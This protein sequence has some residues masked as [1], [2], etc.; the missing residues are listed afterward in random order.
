M[1][2]DSNLNR[3]HL[4]PMILMDWSASMKLFHRLAEDGLVL[5]PESITRGFCLPRWR[6]S[7]IQRGIVCRTGTSRSMSKEPLTH[8]DGS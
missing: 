5:G 2:E 3:H 8:L 6:T 1:H 4:M 7:A